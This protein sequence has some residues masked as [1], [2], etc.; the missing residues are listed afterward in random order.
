MTITNSSNVLDMLNILSNESNTLYEFLERFEKMLRVPGVFVRGKKI[1]KEK[2][3]SSG[4]DGGKQEVTPALHILEN[5]IEL[6]KNWFSKLPLDLRE[7]AMNLL[8]DKHPSIL[9]NSTGMIRKNITRCDNYEI[10][11][12]TMAKALTGIL[13]PFGDIY[14]T[15]DHLFELGDKFEKYLFNYPSI[16][17]RGKDFVNKLIALA[18]NG[19]NVFSNEYSDN[20]QLKNLDKIYI[21][22]EKI[23]DSIKPINKKFI[24]ED[25]EKII[26]EI[27]ENF[28]INK[29]Y[30]YT[31][32][33]K[34]EFISVLENTCKVSNY[35]YEIGGI[36]I[37]RY[38]LLMYFD[39]LIR[40]EYDIDENIFKYV[41]YKNM[42]INEKEF[43]IIEKELENLFP[44]FGVN[45]LK[46]EN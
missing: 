20:S 42:L 18:K 10:P 38:R 30:K 16:V 35:A 4:S 17:C 44:N 32:A 26:E 31:I 9:L 41:L 14:V 21:E 33:L 19:I 12:E 28:K 27:I 25:E 2:D 40:E 6:F 34:S 5:N 13:K 39:A 46:L 22:Q 43:E 36:R 1:F 24:N 8:W 45:T 3:N 23:S 37:S 29:D 15:F 11:I 7:Q